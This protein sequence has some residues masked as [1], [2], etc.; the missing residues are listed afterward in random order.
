M[1]F[2]GS[3]KNKITK[4]KNCENVPNVEIIK[5]DW[6]SVIL[7]IM[8]IK[9]IQECCTRLFQKKPFGSLL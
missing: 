4:N 3:T 2:L 1:K 9:Y 5:V 8:I 7:L 6:F